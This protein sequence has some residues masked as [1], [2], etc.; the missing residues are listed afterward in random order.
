MV[1][2]LQMPLKQKLGVGA[3]F[4]LGFFVVI[5]SSMSALSL[6]DSSFTYHTISNPRLLLQQERD[7]ADMYGLHGGDCRRHYRDLSS[8]F[9]L[10]SHFKMAKIPQLTI[11]VFH[12]TPN[13]HPRSDFPCR[14]L[15]C[16]SLRTR[17]LPPH[18]R[19]GKCSCNLPP[20][21]LPQ[22]RTQC[23]QAYQ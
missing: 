19:A 3:M 23:E 11:S 21:Q 18:S 12:S 5:A 17:L 16:A 7:D 9:V 6:A 20:R 2:K 22:Q 15:F 10:C 14:H 13:N 1:A 8:R 4:A